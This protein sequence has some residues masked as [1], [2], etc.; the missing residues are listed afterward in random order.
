MDGSAAPRRHARKTPR[1]RAGSS[2]AAVRP[3]RQRRLPSVRRTAPL[4]S[5][6]RT[7]AG[8]PAATPACG[9][10][11]A[12]PALRD[13]RTDAAGRAELPPLPAGANYLVRASAAG[14]APAESRW[15]NGAERGA[16]ELPPIVL[17]KLR[18]VTGVVA[19]ADGK[20]LAG[21]TV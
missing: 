7:A 21:A 9:R 20:P 13:L 2:S 17:R 4:R 16:V 19:D 18:T 6:P 11:S 5:R 15:T 3:S 1:A 8:D 12:G 10:T 14:H